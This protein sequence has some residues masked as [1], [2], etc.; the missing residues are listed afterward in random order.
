MYSE[1]AIACFENTLRKKIK[2]PT[3]RPSVTER[4]H[5][6]LLRKRDAQNGVEQN[7]VGK[8]LDEEGKGNAID[9]LDELD[10]LD[11]PDDL[12]VFDP[13]DFCF[14]GIPRFG[15]PHLLPCFW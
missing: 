1:N 12:S 10:E 11:D 8:K 14:F 2:L 9:E 15:I 6:H 7:C 3:S 13:L 4:V 5:K